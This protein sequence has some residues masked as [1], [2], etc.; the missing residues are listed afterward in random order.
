MVL[1]VYMATMYG[2]DWINIIPSVA[3]NAFFIDGFPWSKIMALS[4]INKM[5]S[6]SF[7]KL[8]LLKSQDENAS[9]LNDS[10]QMKNVNV[11]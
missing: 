1:F 11:S 8:W 7:S 4:K 10:N 6:V 9:L 2:D 3:A 5:V